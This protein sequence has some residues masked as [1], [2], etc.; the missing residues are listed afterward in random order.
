MKRF[1]LFFTCVLLIFNFAI[2][3]EKP[4][5]IEEP[6]AYVFAM[7]NRNI[8]D[9]IKIVNKTDGEISDIKIYAWKNEKWTFIDSLSIHGMHMDYTFWGYDYVC[10]EAE[11]DKFKGEY[12]N[13]KYYAL[14]SDYYIKFKVYEDRHD[15]IIEINEFIKKFDKKY[16]IDGKHTIIGTWSDSKT[17]ISFYPDDTYIVEENGALKSVGYYLS[18][19]KDINWD[20]SRRGKIYFIRFFERDNN[21]FKY[22]AEMIKMD[23]SLKDGYLKLETFENNYNRNLEYKESLYKISDEVKKKA[24]ED[25]VYIQNI[26]PIKYEINSNFTL[27]DNFVVSK[28]LRENV[29]NLFPSWKKNYVKIDLN[30]GRFSDSLTFVKQTKFTQNK[31]FE[32]LTPDWNILVYNN[33][34][35]F[36]YDKIYVLPDTIYDYR[37]TAYY[38]KS[39]E[40]IQW[41]DKENCLFKIFPW[42]YEIGL[43]LIFLTGV[44][45][46]PPRFLVYE[47]VFQYET[48]LHSQK[49]VPK[50]RMVELETLSMIKIT[51]KQEWIYNE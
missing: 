33:P 39:G 32:T 11:T 14:V 28:K 21:D 13:T 9:Y 3:E 41:V 30:I 16:D 38:T 44:K 34:Y 26:S 45:T 24:M 46:L 18:D 23:Y 40:V 4:K 35:G 50:F 43:D 7:N 20:E 22:K 37:D 19:G 48:L 25:K 36:E 8:R 29:K 47:G 27:N 2:A 15:L 5:F 12:K 17:I 1:Y 51:N 42:N 10:G 31:E 49:I 6:D